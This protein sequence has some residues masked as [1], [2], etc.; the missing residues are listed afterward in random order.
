[1]AATTITVAGCSHGGPMSCTK[2]EAAVNAYIDKG[3]LTR[4]DLLDRIGAHSEAEA[5]AILKRCSPP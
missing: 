4:A 5:D 1:M 2:V 3:D